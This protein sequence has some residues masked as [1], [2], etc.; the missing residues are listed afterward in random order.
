MEWIALI[1]GDLK[2]CLQLIKGCYLRESES[3]REGGDVF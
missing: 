3:G 2:V 1:D